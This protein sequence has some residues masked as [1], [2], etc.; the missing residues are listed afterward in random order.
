MVYSTAKQFIYLTPRSLGCL[1][2]TGPIPVQGSSEQEKQYL[3]DYSAALSK[4]LGSTDEIVDP[5]RCLVHTDISLADEVWSRCLKAAWVTFTDGR[6]ADFAVVARSLLS[7]PW[8]SKA[9]NFPPLM[10]GSHN[11][12]LLSFSAG[13]EAV[14]WMYPWG[15]LDGTSV[16]VLMSLGF[17][18]G[19]AV[20]RFLVYVLVTFPAN[21]DVCVAGECCSE[22]ASSDSRPSAAASASCGYA[23]GPC[24]GFQRL[25]RGHP[26]L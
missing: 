1:P 5:L 14:V 12:R 8:H 11:V 21:M 20:Y 4:A 9:L 10:Q 18:Y 23:G 19:T 25:A 15:C 6:R 7:K 26:G 22:L 16:S 24:R 2:M 17:F 13:W 3:K